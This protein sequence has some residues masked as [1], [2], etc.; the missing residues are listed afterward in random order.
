M[1]LKQIYQARDHWNP[2]WLSS[3]QLGLSGVLAIE[4]DSYT[5]SLYGVGIVLSSDRDLLVW[6]VNKQTGVVKDNLAYLEMLKSHCEIV[7][8]GWN[9]VLWKVRVQCKIKYF[10]WLSLNHNILTW[11]TLQRRGYNG[12]GCCILC[13]NALKLAENIFGNCVIFYQIGQSLC[14]GLNFLWQWD[15][16]NIADNLKHWILKI[17]MPLE[18]PCITMLEV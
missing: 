8:I 16:S 6:A 3:K 15:C 12:P 9:S 18:V 7:S 5:S 17:H 13:N 11:D 2:R 4:W 1:V 10:C 14:S